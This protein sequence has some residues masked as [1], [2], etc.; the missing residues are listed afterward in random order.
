MPH[1]SPAGVGYH[2][3]LYKEEP[4]FAGPSGSPYQ[5]QY[6]GNAGYNSGGLT[7]KDDSYNS[8]YSAYSEYRSVNKEEKKKSILPDS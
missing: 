2:P 8:P 1:Y 7:F 5:Q 4:S 3:H 6:Y